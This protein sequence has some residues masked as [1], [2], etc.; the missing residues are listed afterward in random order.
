MFDTIATGTL[1]TIVGGTD[2][3]AVKTMAKANGI[4]G[5]MTGLFAG[6]LVG[7]GSPLGAAVGVAA[8][9]SIGAGREYIRQQ[10]G[11]P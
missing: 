2:W 4:V 10:R 8:G 1:E 7:I 5:G 9:A 11:A 6:G 3:Q